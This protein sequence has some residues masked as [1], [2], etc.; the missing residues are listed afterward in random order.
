MNMPTWQWFA[1]RVKHDAGKITI[2][3]YAVSADAAKRVVMTAER[4]PERAILSVEPRTPP[5]MRKRK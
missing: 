5:H 4:C 3:N 2:Y 1:V